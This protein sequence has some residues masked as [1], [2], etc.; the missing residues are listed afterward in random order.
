MHQQNWTFGWKVH[1]GSQVGP[2]PRKLL[3][4]STQLLFWQ[5]SQVL[6]QNRCWRHHESLLFVVLMWLWQ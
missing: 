4:E 5:S 2:P 3:M 1:M 6:H